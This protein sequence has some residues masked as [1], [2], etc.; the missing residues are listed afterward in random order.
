MAKP[1]AETVDA[2]IDQT[3]AQV[4]SLY[5]RALSPQVAMS[6]NLIPCCT[7]VATHA[8]VSLINYGCHSHVHTVLTDWSPSASL[9]LV[10]TGQTWSTET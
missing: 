5:Q 7:H 6:A 9:H 4:L 10:Q 1:K 8:V 2:C 3:L